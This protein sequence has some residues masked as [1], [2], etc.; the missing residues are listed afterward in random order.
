MGA[1]ASRP[2]RPGGGLPTTKALHAAYASVSADEA[3]LIRESFGVLADTPVANGV[4]AIS[5]LA[6]EVLDRDDI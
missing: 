2:G 6:F 4:L 3:T 1:H 5:P